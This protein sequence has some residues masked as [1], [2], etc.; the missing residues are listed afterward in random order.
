MFAEK[1]GGEKTP[2]GKGKHFVQTENQQMRE[3]LCASL[4]NAER[5]L[6]LKQGFDEITRMRNGVEAS[7]FFSYYTHSPSP[8]INRSSSSIDQLSNN[9]FFPFSHDLSSRTSVKSEQIDRESSRIYLR[10]V[11]SFFCFLNKFC[12]SPEAIHDVLV[13][14]QKSLSIHVAT[15]EG[16]KTFLSTRKLSVTCSED[17]KKVLSILLCYLI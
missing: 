9:F 12:L 11:R 6:G 10:F 13:C 1:K 7:S 2:W 4:T 3:K 8:S 15:S 14:T 17:D 5:F 16:K